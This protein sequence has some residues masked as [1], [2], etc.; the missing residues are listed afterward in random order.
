MR[1]VS[2]IPSGGHRTT[3]STAA[4]LERKSALWVSWNTHRRT[5]GLCAAWDIPLHIVRSNRNGLARWIG[6]AVDTLRLLRRQKPEILF[7]Q[8]PSLA[9]TMLAT[10]SRRLFGYYLVVDAHNEGV[11]PF[12]RPGA[13]VGW[14]TRRLLKAADVTI[15]TNAALAR[16]V[17]DAGGRPLVLPDGLPTPPALA[18][19]RRLAEDALHVA[20]IAT[21]RADE[22]IESIISA[23]AT[24]PGIR[25][26]FTGDARRFNMAEN[27]L[28]ANVRL[29]GFLPE[30]AYWQLLEEATVICDLTLK[31]EC[32]VC[33]AYEGLAVG[34]PLVLSDNPPTREIFEP[35]A[36]LTGSAPDEIAKALRTALEQRARL[37]ANALELREAY[38]VR[39]QPQAAATWDAIRAGAA[40]GNRGLT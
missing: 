10:A 29:T 19:K 14:L 36:V 24:M 2:E 1:V 3:S 22:P 15:V 23:A 26:A 40:A 25:F 12:D 27:E 4:P 8:N 32:L 21:Y 17:S 7:V 35:V 38:R 37:E 11:R 16:D 9:L 31:P 20:V 28:P 6:R 13:L 39:W 18:A 5:T 33:G 34:K 30:P